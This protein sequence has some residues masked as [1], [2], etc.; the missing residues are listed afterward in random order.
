[1]TIVKSLPTSLV[2]FQNDTTLSST[3]T[4]IGNIYANFTMAAMRSVNYLVD[5]DYLAQGNLNLIISMSLHSVCQQ[6]LL[7][8]LTVHPPAAIHEAINQTCRSNRTHVKYSS[9]S[10]PSTTCMISDNTFLW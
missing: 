5:V 1:M 2:A 10:G 9:R 7:I 4:V 6:A 8:C 3:E